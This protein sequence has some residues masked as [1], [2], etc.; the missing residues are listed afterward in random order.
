MGYI[1]PGYDA[2][3]VVWNVHPLNVGAT[4]L[5][6]FIDG[7]PVLDSKEVSGTLSNM[8]LDTQR[9]RERGKLNMRAVLDPVVKEQ[10][11]GETRPGNGRT[12]IITGIKASFLETTP[13]PYSAHGNLTLVINNGKL[14][15]FGNHTTCVTASTVGKIIKLDKGYVLPGLTALSTHLGLAEIDMAEETSDGSFGKKSDSLNADNVVFAKYGV[16]LDGRAF[17]RARFGGVTK[18]VTAPMMDGG[19]GGG[20]SVGIK[21]SGKKTILNGGVYKDDVALHFMIGQNSKGKELPPLC[22]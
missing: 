9:E 1:K 19:L 17:K 8:K 12:V 21:T 11:C 13:T 18:A 4:P 7:R 20:V 3:I 16:H 22:S 15:C 2:D 10:I 14:E 5:Q 6:V